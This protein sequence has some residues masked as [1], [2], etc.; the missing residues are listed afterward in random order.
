M[1]SVLLL[2]FLL[3][4]RHSLDAD[5][6]AAVAT[7][8]AEG[9][10]LSQGLRLGLS[11]GVGH[12]L[13]LFLLG[14]IIILSGEVIPPGV[15]GALE[16][17]VG[18]M[19]IV[20]GAGV[21]WRFHRN[22]VHFHIHQHHGQT[23]HFHA[24]SHAGE[25]IPHNPESHRHR[26][27]RGL[28]RKALLVGVVHG[29]AGT[30]ALVLIT[31]NAMGSLAWG[32]VYIALFSLGALAGM[33]LLSTLISLPMEYAARRANSLY[34]GLIISIGAGTVILGLSIVLPVLFS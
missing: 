10:G 26:H 8:S 32:M 24:H 4:L 23:R 34:R 1:W 16:A 5:H 9:R 29:C 17:L 11:W 6:L 15:A 14:S 20:L 31:V 25:S 7:L 28:N 13:P 21:L 27:A 12:A 2:G 3:G 19:L 22:R 33:A 30:A 18:V